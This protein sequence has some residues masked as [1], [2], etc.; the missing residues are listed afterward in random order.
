MI[1]LDEINVGDIIIRELMGCNSLMS[2]K[3]SRV[4]NDR[5]YCGQWEF[6]RTSGME[7]DDSM[8]LPPSIIKAVELEDGLHT[9]I[10]VVYPIPCVNVDN[11]EHIKKPKQR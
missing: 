8:S 7:I 11:W 2:L 9:P 1:K 10:P 4:T 6:C 3:V 5:I